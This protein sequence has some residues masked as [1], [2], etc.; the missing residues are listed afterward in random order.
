MHVCISV[1]IYV[2]LSTIQIYSYYVQ[3]H[4]QRHI[5]K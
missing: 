1:D 3:T 5:K 4:T 2:L